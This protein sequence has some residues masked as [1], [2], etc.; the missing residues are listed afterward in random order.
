MN[1]AQG[2]WIEESRS[3]ISYV[4]RQHFCQGD[5]MIQDERYF[6]LL[7][8]RVDYNLQSG[9]PV[10]SLSLLGFI[11]ENESKQVVFKK[12]DNS[13]SF[14]I[15]DYNVSL[16][17]TLEVSTK[18]GPFIVNSIDSIEYCGR[19]HKRYVNRIVDNSFS[20]ALIEGIGYTNGLLGYEGFLIAVEAYD[21]LKCYT[22]WDNVQCSDCD[23][24]LDEPVEKSY[25]TVYPNPVF[26]KVRISSTF[27]FNR[28]S[29][30]N[31]NG[32]QIFSSEYTNSYSQTI[33]L[34]EYSS[35]IYLVRV[36]F[37]DHSYSNTTIYK[38]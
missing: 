16:G 1:F 19:Y 5:T 27:P 35:G 37:N 34:N 21:R 9:K 3:G 28:V 11:R 29:I 26:E 17:D 18:L 22:E 14:V 15:Y 6:N 38:N 33:P 30:Y 32:I 7:E 36:W 31:L 23:L 20:V 24:L 12:T 10:T 2:V 4:D 25:L 8:L 13:S